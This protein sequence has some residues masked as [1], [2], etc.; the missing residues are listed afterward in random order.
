MDLEEEA[1]ELQRTLAQIDC[2]GRHRARGPVVVT[3]LVVK[4]VSFLQ[5]RMDGNK[6]H[7]RPHVHVIY[8]NDYRAATYAIDNSERLV[9]ALPARHDRA[10]RQWTAGHKP[11]LLNLWAI[12]QAGGSTSAILSELR[13]SA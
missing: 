6:N 1:A 8:G 10:V 9:G 11:K 3:F 12:S 4:L 13:G 2:D 7:Q 5:I